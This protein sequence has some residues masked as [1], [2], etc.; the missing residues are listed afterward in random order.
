MKSKKSQIF[1]PGLVII[2]L[3]ILVEALIILSSK[4]G[5]FKEE[6]LGKRQFDVINTYIEGEGAL[7]YIDQSAKYSAHQTIYDLA[8]KGGCNSNDKYLGYS[9]WNFNEKSQCN[10]GIETAKDNFLVLFSNDLNEF[11]SKYKSIKIPLNNYKL[12]FKD[13][14][15]IGLAI[16]PLKITIGKETKQ[17]GEY[18]IKPSFKVNLNGYDFSDYKKLRL[19]AEELIKSCKDKDTREI[20]KCVNDEKSKIFK[21]EDFDIYTCESEEREALLN[22][23]EYFVSCVNSAVPEKF[24]ESINTKSAGCVCRNQPKEGTFDVKKAGNIVKIIGKVNGKEVSI[25]LENIKIKSDVLESIKEG[26]FLHKD[27]NTGEL[28]VQEDIVINPACILKPQTKFRFC[29]KSTKN[30]VLAYGEEDKKIL[31]RDIEYRFAIDFQ[32]ISYEKMKEFDEEAL[33]ALDQRGFVI[34]VQCTD[35]SSK[36]VNIVKDIG[37]IFEEIA[38]PILFDKCVENDQELNQRRDTLIH[39]DSNVKNDPILIIISSNENPA[40]SYVTDQGEQMSMFVK[41]EF[42]NIEFLSKKLI[43]NTQLL[44]DISPHTLKITFKNSELED[45]DKTMEYANSI[46]LALM[47]YALDLNNENDEDESN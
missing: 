41:E 31:T 16:N 20:K 13:N 1:S 23:T 37:G 44:H 25:E 40:L 19:N 45:S 29:A 35:T 5:I 6:P 2:A 22:F 8:K 38:A 18:S 10:P 43:D 14:N 15:L 17:I 36:V 42:K 34:D 24:F 21:K 47:N 9:L 28:R 46:A 3:L 7:F 27:K 39:F 30:K 33:K 11:L 32:K 4:G 26:M 12:D